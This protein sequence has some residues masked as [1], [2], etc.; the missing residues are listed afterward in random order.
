MYE[1]SLIL[2]NWKK[3]IQIKTMSIKLFEKFFVDNIVE[4][5]FVKVDNDQKQ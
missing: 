4:M 1:L 2:D 5:D 3:I